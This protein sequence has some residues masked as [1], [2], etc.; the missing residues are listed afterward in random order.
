MKFLG[1]APR[2]DDLL[3]DRSYVLGSLL[4]LHH[5]EPC[6]APHRALVFTQ[7]QQMLDILEKHAQAQVRLLIRVWWARGA[8]LLC[9]AAV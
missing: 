9:L 4:I 8:R 1:I 3:V 6:P 7:T 5:N 2:I